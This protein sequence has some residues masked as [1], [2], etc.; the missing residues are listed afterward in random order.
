[1]NVF[2]MYVD[3]SVVPEPVS[4]RPCTFGSQ[5]ARPIGRSGLPLAS[6]AFAIQRTS[7]ASGE[8]TLV[9]DVTFTV[10]PFTELTVSFAFG[11]VSVI[12][13]L[14]SRIIP[15]TIVIIANSGRPE[16]SNGVFAV[17]AVV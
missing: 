14:S 11:V 16:I 2:A 15:G 6:I 9:S 12:D 10:V 8:P 7:V 4:L 5:P 13:D 17:I 1:M 3:H